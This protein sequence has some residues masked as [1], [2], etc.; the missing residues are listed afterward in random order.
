MAEEKDKILEHLYCRCGWKSEEYEPGTYGQVI[1]CP[2]CRARSL[3]YTQRYK[4]K[5]VD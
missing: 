4:H 3:Y 2:E 5:E 1:K